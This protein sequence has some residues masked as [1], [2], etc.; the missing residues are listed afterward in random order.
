M[1][2]D[3]ENIYHRYLNLPFEPNVDLFKLFEYD[4]TK[5]THLTVEV[6]ELNPELVA[7]FDQF[8]IKIFWAEALYTAPG[9]KLPVHT[10]TEDIS[11]FI[12]VNWTYGAPGS[13]TRWWKTTPEN[14][15]KGFPVYL[16][17]YTKSTEE[18][19]YFNAPL[20]LAEEQ[21]CTMVYEAEI[22]KPSLVNAGEFHSTYN[23][24]Q[25][26][27]WTLA[28]PLINKQTEQFVTWSEAIEKF[29]GY[30]IK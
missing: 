11:E 19:T 27:R 30:I 17:C 18:P 14:Y 8:D 15:I 10:D 2:T 28:L 7:W 9:D 25:E 29:N 12:K 5:N 24:T 1:L 21:N 3:K 6:T 26:G 16:D 22:N 20:L 4:P 23:P 13:T